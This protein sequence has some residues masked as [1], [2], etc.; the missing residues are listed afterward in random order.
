MSKLKKLLLGTALVGTMATGLSECEHTDSDENNTDRKPKKTQVKQDLNDNAALFESSRSQI[1]F[2]LTFV[3]NYYPYIYFC[4]RAWTTGAGLTVLY[5][6][7]G[8]YTQVTQ[9]TPVPTIAQSDVYMG[10]Y[11][12][13]E[14][15]PDIKQCITVPMDR[16]TLIAACALRYCIGHGNF[17]KSAFVKQLNAG[18]RGAELAKTLTGWRKQ[19]GVPKRLYFFAAMMSGKMTFSDML[20]LRAEGCYNLDWHDIFVYSGKEPKCDKNKFFEWDFTKLQANLEKAKAPKNTV[21]NL[22]RGKG[23]VTVK[24]KLV[25]DI[26]PDYI[27]DDVTRDSNTVDFAKLIQ[28]TKIR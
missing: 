28:E 11:M 22:G 14:I 3:E 15:L 8:T 21:L 13:F 17:V 1:K 4:G 27:W 2:S 12:T 25:K 7:N 9:K 6:P 18:V 19:E 23:T 26:V 5:K 10:R 16:E 24:C 20:N